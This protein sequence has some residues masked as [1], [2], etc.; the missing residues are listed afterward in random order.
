ML[1]ISVVPGKGNRRHSHRFSVQKW[2]V[3]R[4]RESSGANGEHNIHYV[5]FVIP[6]SAKVS[7]IQK[8][9]KK[10]VHYDFGSFVLRSGW[11][12]F[13]GAN[14]SHCICKNSCS[15]GMS[16][17]VGTICQFPLHKLAP[18]QKFALWRWG[19]WNI[20]MLYVSKWEQLQIV[21]SWWR[22]CCISF[23]NSLQAKLRWRTRQNA[24]MVGYIT[25]PHTLSVCTL[26]SHTYRLHQLHTTHVTYF[27]EE[28]PSGRVCS[29][30][31]HCI[32]TRLCLC[33]A[34]CQL[35]C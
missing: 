13:V 19:R 32:I 8:R 17:N 35:L 20:L 23:H 18:C 22:Y 7:F 26:I 5:G 28:L 10:S 14:K 3:R 30:H 33:T 6:L 27:W 16:G 2:E 34:A 1:S 4:I 31:R 11:Y 9:Q 21:I 24:R 15:K 29:A 25:L 12:V